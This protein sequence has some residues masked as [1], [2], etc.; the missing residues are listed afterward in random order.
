MAKMS[1]ATRDA[2]VENAVEKAGLNNEREQIYR[3]RAILAEQVR[4]DALGGIDSVKKLDKLLSDTALNLKDFES[5][6]PKPVGLGV[7]SSLHYDVYA[8]FAG[9][10]LRLFF[11]GA[12][13]YRDDRTDVHKTRPSRTMVYEADHPFVREHER[14]VAWLADWK[15]RK[16][17]LE[18][19]VRGTVSKFHSVANLLKAW[20]EAAELLPPDTIKPKAQLPSVPVA[21]LN[22][23]IGLPTGDDK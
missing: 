9:A 10:D 5:T 23:L 8:R 12:E 17:T 18:A 21:N 15:G 13:S 7:H 19:Q 1:N 16:D 22:A 14:I 20:P 6:L 2:I 4:V 11:N 3:S